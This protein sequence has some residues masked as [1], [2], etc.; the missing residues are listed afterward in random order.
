M[1]LFWGCIAASNCFLCT[2]SISQPQ[3]F[4]NLDGKPIF[5]IDLENTCYPAKCGLNH[6]WWVTP[7]LPLTFWWVK[8]CT[9]PVAKQQ[10]FMIRDIWGVSILSGTALQVL[11]YWWNVQTNYSLAIPHDSANQVC[12]LE[13]KITHCSTSI[14]SEKE[15]GS[16]VKYGER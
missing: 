9:W 3:N 4:P 6:H 12:I 11:H 13:S 16:S 1:F 5:D 8:F 7:P 10:R 15:R 14:N 2:F